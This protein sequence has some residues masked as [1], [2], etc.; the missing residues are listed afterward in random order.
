MKPTCLSL[1]LDL[2][3]LGIF[4]QSLNHF[5]HKRTTNKNLAT[6]QEIFK[7]TLSVEYD[8]AILW[9]YSVY[10]CFIIFVSGFFVSL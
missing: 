5:E 1:S 2:A 7:N 3:I 9:V 6:R 8:F 10:K 4:D